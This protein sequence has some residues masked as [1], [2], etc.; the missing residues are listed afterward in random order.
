[1]K[2]DNR[3]ETGKLR[4]TTPSGKQM[5]DEPEQSKCVA[6]FLKYVVANFALHLFVTPTLNKI[7]KFQYSTASLV[8]M[9]IFQV[10]FLFILA[11][12][13]KLPYMQILIDLMIKSKYNIRNRN[14]DE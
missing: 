13:Y 3:I 6:R 14:N 8:G 4:A 10:I 9:I 12:H 5:S 1:M 7:F 2:E 11:E